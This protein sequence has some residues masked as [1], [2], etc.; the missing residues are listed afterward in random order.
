M[1]RHIGLVGPKHSGKSTSAE[2]LVQS[3]G[4]VRESLAGPLKDDA[5]EMINTFNRRHG[6]PG[7]NRDYLDRH[8][9]EVFVP[10]LQWLGTEYGREFLKTPSRWT[11]LFLSRAY[12]S[13]KP[14]VCDDVRFINEADILRANG[15]LIIK[16]NRSD[17]ARE[18]SLTEAGVDPSTALHTSETELNK[19]VPDLGIHPLSTR[20][21]DLYA[22]LRWC[23]DFHKACQQLTDI[24]SFVPYQSAPGFNADFSEMVEMLFTHRAGLDITI[25]SD[26]YKTMWDRMLGHMV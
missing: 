17:W 13:E 3:Y 20:L 15:F 5:V 14:V 2:F 24:L 19:I 25:E 26:T 22:H 12:A 18:Q 21:Y 1:G 4:F 16:I 7:I 9:D 8:K 23:M 10:F 11:D 6:L